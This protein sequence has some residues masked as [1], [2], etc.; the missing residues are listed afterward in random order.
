MTHLLCQAKYL[1]GTRRVD[2]Y[3]LVKIAC[4]KWPRNEN[5]LDDDEY[6]LPLLKYDTN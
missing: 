5:D 1:L 6:E 4:K 3:S 2:Q